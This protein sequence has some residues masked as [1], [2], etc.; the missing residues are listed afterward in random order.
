MDKA[1]QAFEKMYRDILDKLDH[2][3][4]GGL[5]H[6]ECKAY[7]WGVEEAFK[8]GWKAAMQE[9][10]KETKEMSDQRGGES[11][12]FIDDTCEAEADFGRTIA[13]KLATMGE[14]TM[15][16]RFDKPSLQALLTLLEDGVAYDPSWQRPTHYDLITTAF[17]FGQCHYKHVW[18]IQ[19]WG[20]NCLNSVRKLH[21]E[22][23]PDYEWIVGKVI[24][25]GYPIAF[26]GIYEKQVDQSL[27]WLI[28]I[29]ETL[30]E[31]D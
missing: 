22:V 15:T 11:T 8:D 31:E 10:A 27:A 29:I 23:L 4:F 14:E 25:S 3:D 9:A 2:Y 5:P 21:E 24:P 30:I 12:E 6:D 7:K 18:V 1:K 13:E 19:A 28:Q 26:R 16:K 17:G 20:N